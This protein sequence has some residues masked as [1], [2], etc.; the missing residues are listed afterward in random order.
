MSQRSR[1]NKIANAEDAFTLVFA[2]ERE[3]RA[4]VRASGGDEYCGYRGYRFVTGHE[5]V[6]RTRTRAGKGTIPV[7]GYPYPCCSLV[8]EDP[9]KP[10]PRPD[11]P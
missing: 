7:A 8:P 1:T 11:R 2:H 3:G 9:P 10:P 5:I 4:R 6:T